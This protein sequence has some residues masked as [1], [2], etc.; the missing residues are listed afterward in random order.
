MAL[1]KNTPGCNCCGRVLIWDM[2][3]GVSF[4]SI[5]FGTEHTF[6]NDWEG[7]ADWINGIGIAEAE[8]IP[9]WNS[10]ESKVDFA[11]GNTQPPDDFWGHFEGNSNGCLEQ[12]PDPVSQ[13]DPETDAVDLGYWTGDIRDYS[14]ILWSTPFSDG[15]DLF[16]YLAEIDPDNNDCNGPG[17][18]EDS[19]LC[20]QEHRDALWMWG[21][22]PDWW[23]TIVN[24][25]WSGRLVILL[26]GARAM[27]QSSHDPAAHFLNDYLSDTTEITADVSERT[28]TAS[29]STPFADPEIEPLIEGVT[30]LAFGPINDLVGG[31]PLFVR[32]VTLRHGC[33]ISASGIHSA[34][35]NSVVRKTKMV[36]TE[37]GVRKKVEF[38]VCSVLS[39]ISA[40]SEEEDENKQFVI[41]LFQKPLHS[42]DDP[43]LLS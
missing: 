10:E 43:E 26:G 5:N 8:D 32:S 7:L 28:A 16:E 25:E 23:Q 6:F 18:P 4:D 33:N 24:G 38:V 17:G 13:F 2:G 27:R 39:V 30:Q 9:A 12:F 31:T 37:E 15:R 21:G 35:I 29:D 42:I 41:N 22:V 14:L 34:T 40:T 36:G 3:S 1:K 20:P 11:L 19:V